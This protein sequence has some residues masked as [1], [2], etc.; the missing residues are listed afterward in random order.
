MAKKYAKKSVSQGVW[1]R[2]GEDVKDQDLVEIMNEGTEEDG[3]FGTQDVFL[4]KTAAG[5]EGKLSFNQTSL[6][7]LIDAFG[8]D[9][10]NWVG[11]TV[12]VWL[13]KDF[14]DGKLVV[15]LII[16]HPEAIL[17]NAGFVTPGKAAKEDIPIVE[18][19]EV[20]LR[21]IPF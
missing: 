12:K 13:F 11:K 1:L 10:V 21:D 9:A 7:N 4:V 19:N 17:T 3:Q 14:K 8:D 20:D 6:N 18:E 2:K 5:K 16:T 15:K